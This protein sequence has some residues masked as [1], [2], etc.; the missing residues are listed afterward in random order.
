[1]AQERAR[2]GVAGALP[3]CVHAQD[4]RAANAVRLSGTTRRCPVCRSLR[5]VAL[6]AGR[7][8][9]RCGHLPAR[10]EPHYCPRQ[11]CPARCARRP[12][13]GQDGR[14]GA[15]TGPDRHHHSRDCGERK[16]P[17]RRRVPGVFP[18]EE[19]ATVPVWVPGRL[20]GASR[21]FVRIVGASTTARYGPAG[22]RSQIPRRAR[23]SMVADRPGA[24]GQI[25]D[26]AVRQGWSRGKQPVL[27][28][29]R[30]HGG[31][32]VLRHGERLDSR[33]EKCPGQP[34][35]EIRVC[36]CLGPSRARHCPTCLGDGFRGHLL[37]HAPSPVPL[38]L[39]VL[40]PIRR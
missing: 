24:R 26:N 7:A 22:T 16:G 32:M 36:A 27:R 38:T 19:W 9:R 17:V 31:A 11:S 8:A 18:G 12:S 4:C 14:R 29:C 30:A 33:P 6:S 25:D 20:R 35:V 40:A 23:M 10:Q 34:P 1:M 2:F 5:Q 28:Q 15:T 37:H 39:P 3:A 13:D 21:K